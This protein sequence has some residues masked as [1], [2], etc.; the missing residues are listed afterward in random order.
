[1]EKR[2]PQIF[3]LKF[4]Y[5]KTL[6]KLLIQ[7]AGTGKVPDYRTSRLL[8]STY[9]N[10]SSYPLVLLLLIQYHK[11]LQLVLLFVCVVGS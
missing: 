2:V 4:F 7:Q 1:M 5:I 9:S 8:D 6:K 3:L 10:L 11:R